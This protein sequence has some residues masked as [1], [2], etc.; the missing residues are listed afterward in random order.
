MNAP[1]RLS[2]GNSQSNERPDPRA[3]APHKVEEHREEASHVHPRSPRIMRTCGLFTVMVLLTLVFRDSFPRN[4]DNWAS[5][6]AECYYP[7]GQVADEGQLPGD[8]EATWCEQEHSSLAEISTKQL[9]ARAGV[10]H[11]PDEGSNGDSNS[12]AVR[13]VTFADDA[14][15]CGF[16]RLAL[17][18]EQYGV[19]LENAALNVRWKGTGGKVEILAAWLQR[20]PPTQLVMVVDGFD[21]AFVGGGGAILRAYA[22]IVAGYQTSRRCVTASSRVVFAAEGHLH[23]HK[24]SWSPTWPDGKAQTQ[25]SYPPSPTRFRYLNSGTIMGPAGEILELLQAAQ[26]DFGKAT[27]QRPFAWSGVDDQVLISSYCAELW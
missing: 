23:W 6:A 13:Y 7:H 10:K 22:E 14:T 26:A 19:V 27:T 1:H 11:V 4:L 15:G 12:S 3:P 25:A 9:L 8:V 5:S 24:T 16:R 20:V 18:A 2:D 21:V 17:S